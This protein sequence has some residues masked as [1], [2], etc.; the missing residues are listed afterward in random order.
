MG[1]RPL[2]PVA[3]L[4]TLSRDRSSPHLLSTGLDLYASPG[5]AKARDAAKAAGVV[6]EPGVS[7][8]QV[9]EA[10]IAFPTMKVV[11]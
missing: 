9:V 6:T 1:S 2:S 8:G 4:I 10:V 3:C 5:A 7:W 11:E